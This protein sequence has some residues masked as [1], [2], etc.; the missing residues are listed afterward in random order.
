M[1]RF[2]LTSL[3]LLLIGGSTA[4]ARLVPD[5]DQF[6]LSEMTNGAKFFIKGEYKAGSNS[7]LLDTPRWLGVQYPKYTDDDFMVSRELDDYPGDPYVFEAFESVGD[8]VAGYPAFYIKNVYTGKWLTREDGE[9]YMFMQLTDNQED[10]ALWAFPPVKDRYPDAAIDDRVMHM[11]CYANDGTSTRFYNNNYNYNSKGNYAYEARVAH[12]IDGTTWLTIIPAKEETDEKEAAL[13][14]LMEVYQMADKFYPLD[15]GDDPG[16]YGTEFAQGFN[17]TFEESNA[18]YIISTYGFVADK[19]SEAAQNLT[20]YLVTLYKGAKTPEDGG[21]YYMVNAFNNWTQPE[22]LRAAYADGTLGLWGVLEPENATYIWQ[23]ISLGNGTYAVK[24]LET[25][26]YLNSA[27][28]SS[29]VNLGDKDDVPVTCKQLAP[30]Q[31]NIYLAPGN[32]SLH[33]MG[34]NG[35]AS[36]GNTLCDF[37]GGANTQSAWYI[38]P[39]DQAIVESLLDKVARDQEAKKA[40]KALLEH[41][42][43]FG[44][45]LKPAFEYQIPATAKDITPTSAFDFESN[46][47][48]QGGAPEDQRHGYSWGTD[49]QGYGALIDNNIDTWF[50]TVYANNGAG[51][52]WSAY[53]DDGTPAEWATPTTLHNLSMKLAEPAS[54]VTFLVAPRNSAYYNSPTKIDVDVSHDGKT[55]T[56]ISYGYD[57]FTTSTN[58]EKPFIMGTFDLGDTYE[59]VRFG[60]YSTDRS[61]TRFFVF[62]EL[63]VYDGAELTPTCQAATMDQEVLKGFLEA[64]STANKYADVV[65]GDDLET[66]RTA[67][68]N[69]VSAYRD[70]MGV[71]ADPDALNATMK[72]AAPIIANFKIADD[73]IGAYRTGTDIKPL[74]TAYEN[75]EALLANGYYTQEAVNDADSILNLEMNKLNDYV[76]MPEE[77]KW[78]QFRFASQDEW[79]TYNFND[80]P[81]LIDRVATYAAGVYKDADTVYVEQYVDL[82]EVREDSKFFSVPYEELAIPELSYFRFIPVDDNRYLIQN[83]GTGFYI[84]YVTGRGWGCHA[85]LF[86]AAFEIKPVGA[87]FCVFEMYNWFTGE[88]D[89]SQGPFTL[90]FC[91]PAQSYEVVT[92]VEHTLGNKSSLKCIA[93]DEDD[94]T[95]GPFYRNT[96]E[97]HMYPV[98]FVNDVTEVEGGTLYQI[99]GQCTEDDNRYIALEPIEGTLPAG[100]PAIILAD[101][102]MIAITL[103]DGLSKKDT[104]QNG[105]VGVL[106]P[107]TL[108]N[109]GTAAIYKYN[110][111]AEIEHTWFPI[112][113]ET[114]ETVVVPAGQ[115]YF[116][117]FAEVPTIA[118]DEIEVAMLVVGNT[119]PVAADVDGNGTVNSADV[120]AIYNF[121]LIGEESGITEDAADVDKN[122]NVNSADVVAVYNY[123]IGPSSSESRGFKVLKRQILDK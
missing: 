47:A 86:P 3:M 101:D 12:F 111:D 18:D 17:S 118:Y 77:G 41:I 122:G 103:G 56:T 57:F 34:H 108:K 24:N 45:K 38:R 33:P 22:K 89:P 58:A 63:K 70:V 73:H 93:V 16:Y 87:G 31:Y 60:N 84:P 40:Q 52:K 117:L 68:A 27:N 14:E 78:Y 21:Y 6:P 80:G 72:E 119:P 113:E 13:S 54:K 19:L 75:A 66:I 35:G 61:G 71:Y 82:S 114:T 5:K 98:T 74:Q 65:T 9:N 20:P 37:P 25:G 69:L 28:R 8:S 42:K 51:V 7:E 123:I 59:Y 105:L 36:F 83:K 81:K 92:W 39:V 46:G 49:G 10:A 106:Q 1:K 104:I 64:Y 90:H 79:D 121:I 85:S 44:G 23:F 109:N 11:V 53:N 102:D 88:K 48:M 115:A 43:E 62:S 29:T 30:G 32:T 112:D 96:E 110:L 2:L 50:H 99:A 107:D 94:Q 95:I 100:T 15:E 91:N 120:V 97:G 116:K 76:V 26:Q 55:W 4:W 67:D